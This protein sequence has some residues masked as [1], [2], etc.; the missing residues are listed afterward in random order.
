M[1]VYEQI[2]LKATKIDSSLDKI[3]L[4]QQVQL[5]KTIEKFEHR[6][7]RAEKKK[8]ETTIAQIR[9]LKEKL[10]PNNSLQERHDNFLAYY[11]RYGNLFLDI[12]KQNLYPLEKKFIVFSD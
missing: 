11:C 8:N 1:E 6:L 7:L 5:L 3:V 9:R 12:L 2:M 4:A 10:F